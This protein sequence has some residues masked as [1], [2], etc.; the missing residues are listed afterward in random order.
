MN[1]FGSQTL[2]SSS[3]NSKPTLEPM[4]PSANQKLNLKHFGCMIVIKLQSI[5]LNSSSSLHMFSG[6]KPHSMDRLTMDLPNESRM[7]W[8]TTTSQICY[9]VSGNSY[10]PLTHDTGNDAVKFPEKPEHLDLPETSLNTSLTLTSQTTNLAK[11]LHI[12][13]RRTPT[14]ALPRTRAPPLIGS[15]PL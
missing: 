8:S 10:K 12:Q 3:R 2:L 4:I 9:P 6:A 5:S 14:L 11:A 15:P 13:S 7:I 1:P